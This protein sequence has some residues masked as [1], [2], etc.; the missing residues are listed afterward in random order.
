MISYMV[1]CIAIWLILL[2]TLREFSAVDLTHRTSMSV[3]TS[4]SLFSDGVDY[5]KLCQH[6]IAMNCQFVASRGPGGVRVKKQ[7]GLL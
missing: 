3:P 5:V 6:K 1:I 2:H 4:K 7:P